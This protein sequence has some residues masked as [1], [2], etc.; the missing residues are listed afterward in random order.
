M[1]AKNEEAFIA[2][3]ISSVAEI[4]S[5]VILVDTGSE[6]STVK[7]AEDLGARV[8]YQPWQDDFSKPRNLSLQYA[9]SDWILILDADEVIAEQDLSKLKKLT[10]DP[11]RCIEFLQRH[12][13]DDHRLS[14]F[15]PC[16]GEFPELER[17]HGGYFESNLVRLFPNHDGIHYRGRVHELVEHSIR[18][19]GKHRIE[20]TEVRIHHYGH[21]D[22]VKREKKKSSIYTPLGEAKTKE[23]PKDWKNFFELGVEHNNNGNLEE[24]LAAFRE[25]ARLN[26]EYLSTWINM[27][28]VQC[29]LGAFQDAVGSLMT[30]IRIDEKA[31]EAYCNLGVVFLRVKDY[32]GAEKH[33]RSAI[34]FNPSYVNAYCNLGT[35][36]ALQERFSESVAVFLRVLELFPTCQKAHAEV[37][38]LYLSK[39]IL[40]RAESHLR[41]AIE[42]HPQDARTCLHLGQL[43]KAQRRALEAVAY[44][45]RFIDLH[46][47]AQGG[48]LSGELA[49]F[50]RR[51]QHECDVLSNQA[52]L[53]KDLG[54]SVLPEVRVALEAKEQ[55]PQVA[56]KEAKAPEEKKDKQDSSEPK[57]RSRKK[58]SPKESTTVKK[59]KSSSKATSKA[60]SSKGK[61]R[62]KSSSAKS[63]ESSSEKPKTSRK[64]KAKRSSKTTSKSS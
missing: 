57:G 59:K 44:F 54:S 24:S 58:S 47:E 2:S 7:I 32:S 13:T 23:Q 38:A 17:N 10:S 19:I 4:V 25:A 8:Y 49:N 21:I 30:A 15:T 50:A 41:R 40:P 61:T 27:G 18:D 36:L 35:C 43:Y 56:P 9:K 5:E 39:N 55:A 37:G 11:L 48:Q 45:Q 16:Q 34:H 26:P 46:L 1:I 42:L 6:D 64:K 53:G 12:Y 31:D 63:K 20:R 14:N 33:F 51:L 3:A 60:S 29:E 22:S 28:Y 52:F 62:K